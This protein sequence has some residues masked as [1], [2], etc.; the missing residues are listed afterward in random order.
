MSRSKTNLGRQPAFLLATTY[1][2]LGYPKEAKGEL[3]KGLVLAP[4][5]AVA[6]TLRNY[7]AGKV[8]SAPLLNNGPQVQIPA[9]SRRAQR[10]AMKPLPPPPPA[11]ENLS[12]T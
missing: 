5:D 1:G 4:D 9:A 8:N 6:F 2:F 7:F 10:S 3:D 11:A 12:V